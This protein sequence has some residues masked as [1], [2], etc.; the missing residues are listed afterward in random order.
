MKLKDLFIKLIKEG[1]KHR[2]NELEI[3]Y[4]LC[5][6]QGYSDV[7]SFYLK[8]DDE[9]KR[10]PLIL[11]DFNRLKT[12][13]P[14]A[15]IIKET[16]FL[17]KRYIVSEDVL[18]PRVETE[19]LLTLTIRRI[20]Q[21]LKNQELKILDVGTG[22]GVLAIELMTRYCCLTDATDINKKAL[23]VA[24]KN[25]NRYQAKVNFYFADT[26]PNNTNQYNAIVS[27]PPYIK[28]KKDVAKDV[29]NY[30]PHSALFLKKDNDVYEKIFK[31]IK[32]RTLR[33][34]LIIFEIAPNIK[35]HLNKLM[36]EYLL[37]EKC[38]FIYSKD[39][40]NKERF[41]TIILE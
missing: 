31:Q 2:I 33:P 24:Q 4:L 19:E 7:A 14:I 10:L 41:L 13:Y 32:T 16:D 5:F 11:N 30:E 12:G 20:E 34:C 37:E 25:A 39:I 9:V 36:N 17:S 38:H 35:E 1:K 3:R 27:N 28:Y 18:I 6:Y 8:L 21:Y 40:N 23:L 15:Y 29:L 26:Y 22:S